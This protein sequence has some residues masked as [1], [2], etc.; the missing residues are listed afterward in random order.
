V[1]HDVCVKFRVFDSGGDGI[2]DPGGY[3]VMLDGEEVANGDNFQFKE[4]GD[5]KFGETQVYYWRL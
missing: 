3:S 5:F 4:G 1:S 2:Q